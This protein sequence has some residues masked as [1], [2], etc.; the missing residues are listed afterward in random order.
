[1]DPCHTD[2]LADG[3]KSRVPFL[4]PGLSLCVYLAHF[5]VF[6]LFS[7]MVQGLGELINSAVGEHVFIQGSV[8]R[9]FVGFGC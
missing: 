8:P 5:S 9:N 2:L 1:M 6:L 4:A 3:A 7:L